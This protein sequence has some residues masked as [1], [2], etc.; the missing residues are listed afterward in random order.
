MLETYL[1]P[2]FT[3]H[4]RC[5]LLGGVVVVA[6]CCVN[7]HQINARLEQTHSDVC[8][9]SPCHSL[10]FMSMP[11]EARLNS[12]MSSSPIPATYS[13]RCSAFREKSMMD[14]ICCRMI[15]VFP[16]RGCLWPLCPLLVVLNPHNDRST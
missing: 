5:V 9:C 16:D 13:V 3:A 8:C 6:A 12:V 14:L 11:A 2:S 10:G 15:N 7:S 4:E 1:I